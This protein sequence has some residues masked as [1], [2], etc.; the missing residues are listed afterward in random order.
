MARE[1]THVTTDVWVATSRNHSTTSTVIARDGRALLVD[2]A[3]EIDELISLSDAI[4][5]LGLTITAG[6]H[7]H[8]HHDHLLWNASFGQ[9]PRWATATAVDMIGRFEAEL[10]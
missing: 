9:V 7:T 6:Y 8:A 1:L 5:G 10:R 4:R 3:W 2:P